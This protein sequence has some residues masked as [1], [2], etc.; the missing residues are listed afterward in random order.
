MR[1]VSENTEQLNDSEVIVHLVIPAQP[2]AVGEEQ[3]TDRLAGGCDCI[4]SCL[5]Q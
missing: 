3:L 4:V 5:S 2:V 1:D